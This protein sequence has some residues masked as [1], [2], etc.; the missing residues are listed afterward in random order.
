M[1]SSGNVWPDVPAE[2]IFNQYLSNKPFCLNML[3]LRM[4]W[5]EL[6]AVRA[7]LAR[8]KSKRRGSKRRAKELIISGSTPSQDRK[9]QLI[10]EKLSLQSI[11][12][13]PT[14]KAE[15]AAKD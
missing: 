2:R 4:L 10:D 8:I 6:V 7:H 13:K 1:M 15:R 11:K 14:A 12:Q 9:R 3:R 5:L